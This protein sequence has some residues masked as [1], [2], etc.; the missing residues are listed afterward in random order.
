MALSMTLQY[1]DKQALPAASILGIIQDLKLSGAQYSWA[2]SIF[3]FGYLASTY[4]T[5]YLMVR[6]PIGKVL[7]CTFV[8]WAVMIGC[9]AT[10]KNFGGLMA[11]RALLGMAEAAAIPGFSLLTGMFYKRQEHALRHGLWFIG[12]SLGIMIAG[13]LSFGIAHVKSGI[14]AWKWL[15]VTLAVITFAWAVVMFWTLPDTPATAK[16]LSKE[17]RIHAVER[18]RSNQMIVKNN[19]FQWYQFREALLDPRIWLLCLFLMAVSICSS[20]I[21]AVLFVP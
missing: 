19:Q 9:H 8:G 12:N 2:S 20:S 4:A 5:P 7:S 10:L 11:V 14:G 17:R 13:L 21:A 6:L 16:F 3:W 15:F 18:L 1:M